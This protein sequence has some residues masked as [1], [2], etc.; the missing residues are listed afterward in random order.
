MAVAMMNIGSVHM[1]VRY[2]LVRVQMIVPPY[3]VPLLMRVLV[4]LVVLVQM[5]MGHPFCG[6]A[7]AGAISAA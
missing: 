3:Q 7:G 6:G 4:V 2:W 5:G 1:A